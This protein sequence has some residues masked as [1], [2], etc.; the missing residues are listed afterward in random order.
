MAAQLFIITP[1]SAD[2]EAFPRTLMAVLAAAPVSAILVRRGERNEADYAALATAIINVGQGAGCAVLVED[3][4]ALVKRLGAD[5]VHVTGD[6]AAVKAA[7]K[8]LK[9]GFIVGAGNVASRH[10]AM[11]VG[12]MDV[13]Y[14]F[15]GPLDGASDATAND[16]ALWWADTF[17]IPAV[18]SDPAATPETT[19]AAAVEFVALSTSLWN[20]Q[21]AATA[22][23]F[24][25]AMEQA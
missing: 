11:T 15:F 9:P 4:A 16:L 18:L 12:E 7:V 22:A 2:P 21:P 17:E 3:D 23:R 8:A 20:D 24:A 19:D 5:G 6:A 13:D 14:L 1:A 10:D 25:A